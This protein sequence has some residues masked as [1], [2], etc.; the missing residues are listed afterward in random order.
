MTVCRISDARER[1]RLECRADDLIRA[2]HGF[3]SLVQNDRDLVIV[4]DGHP[5]PWVIAPEH[6]RIALEVMG[7]PDFADEVLALPPEPGHVK[8]VVAIGNALQ[9]GWTGL[10]PLVKGGAA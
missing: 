10:R 3:I 8:V 2:L 7:G 4:L 6:A 9:V 5:T 1:R